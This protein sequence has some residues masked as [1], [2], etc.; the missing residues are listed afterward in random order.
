MDVRWAQRPTRSEPARGRHELRRWRPHATLR[1][2]TPIPVPP[3]AGTAGRRWL[4]TVRFVVCMLACGGAVAARGDVEK[5][6]TDPASGIQVEVEGWAG[7]VSPVTGRDV[8]LMPVTVT[9]TNGSPADHVWTV[10]PT[11]G[12]GSSADVTPSGRIAV[13]AGATGRMTLFV[14][15]SS[16]GWGG[17]QTFQM[18]GHGVSTTFQVD[19]SRAS[20]RHGGGTLLQ[21]GISKEVQAAQ[22]NPFAKFTLTGG[23][24]DMARAP[25]DWRGW[26]S[27]RNVLLTEGEWQGLAGGRRKALLDWA[28]TGGRAGVLVADRAAERLG[29][30]GFPT[31]GPDGR[32][33]IGAGEIVVVP[34]D[35]S[36]LAAGDVAAFL[37]G[38]TTFEDALGDYHPLSKASGGRHYGSV[39][40][41]GGWEPGFGRLFDRFGPRGL[42]VGSILAFLAIFG[43]VAGPL[44]VMVL[45]GKGRRSRMFWTT[46]VISLAA[47]A[48][49]LSLMFLR[50]GVGGAGGRR[51]L[52]LLAPE[53]NTLAI[54][55]EQFSRTGVL[56]GSSF[57]IAEPAWLEPLGPRD[58][59][60]EFIEADG[61]TR[62]GDWF[63]S[64]SDQAFLATAVRP[65]RARIEFVPGADAAP[66]AV[67]S[68]IEVPLERLFVIDEEGRYWMA[69]DV[70][71]GEKKPLVAS[72]A[73]AY[74]KWFAALEADAGPVRRQAVAAVKNLR[75]HAY[76]SSPQAGKVAV[77]TLGSIRWIDERADFVGPYTRSGPR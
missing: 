50:D 36:K 28:A 1:I 14:G 51:V 38:R 10:A 5:L 16:G 43:L 8:G 72:D 42:P 53:H 46:P 3:V 73:D 52:G 74:A 25:E 13:A 61:R 33:R 35:G 56:L 44:N 12:Y 60:A 31:A 22:G 24:L 23:S 48:C 49:L 66:P 11:T 63:R 69:A 9:I 30:L 54:I 26:T 58:D 41:G 68:S 57:P 62:Q 67:I 77:A 21:C 75:G 7:H 34:W 55:Q 19:C 64:R 37:D 27:F 39:P 4:P 2:L 59:Q 70:G 15:S 17:R 45:A 18:T 40:T 71:T 6:F 65:S 32:R 20:H 47:T 76:A 29:R